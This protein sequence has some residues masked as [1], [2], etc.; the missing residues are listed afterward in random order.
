MA[1]VFVNPSKRTFGKREKAPRDLVFRPHAAGISI[2]ERTDGGQSEQYLGFFA[3]AGGPDD[4]CRGVLGPEELAQAEQQ[5]FA[6]Q[7]IEERKR[8]LEIRLL[9]KILHEYADFLA[10]QPRDFRREVK[11]EISDAINFL[12]YRLGE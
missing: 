9:P 11:P 6:V 10:T 8:Q 2:S 4:M 7:E 1:D 3:Y 5:A 12:M